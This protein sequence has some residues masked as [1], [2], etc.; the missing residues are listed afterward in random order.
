MEPIENATPLT[1]E[2]LEIPYG[3]VLYRTTSIGKLTKGVGKLTKGA[4]VILD[5]GKFADRA[6]VYVDRV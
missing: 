2:S 6:H 5:L 4:D 1:F 3:Y